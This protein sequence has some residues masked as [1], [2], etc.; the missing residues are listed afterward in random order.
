MAMLDRQTLIDESW[1]LRADTFAHRISG[2]TWQRY[3]WIVLVMRL[4]QRALAHGGARIIINAPPRHGKSQAMSRYLPTWLLNW[5]PG[6]R[7]ILTSYGADF[8]AQ[9]GGVVR[10][11]M[12]N[13][14]VWTKVG[15]EKARRDD[16]RTEEGTGGMLTAGA[17]GPVTGQGGDVILVDDPHKNWEEAMSPT[18]REKTIDWFN[19]TLYTRAEPG[20]SIIVTQTRWHPGDLT[21][22][23]LKYHTDD[24]FHINLPALAEEDDPLGR[25][26][27]EPLCPERYTREDLLRIKAAVGSHIFSGLYQQRPTPLEGGVIKRAWIRHWDVLSEGLE[28]WLTSW[29][30]NFKKTKSGSFVT[31][32]VWAR[33]G[34]DFYLV[35]QYRERADFPTTMKAFCDLAKRYPQVSTHLVESA[36][37]G[38]AI[39]SMLRDK[40]PG[41]V[42]VNVGKD[43]KETRLSAVSSFFESGNVYFPPQRLGVWVD[44]LIEEVVTFPNSAENDQCDSLSQALD[45]YKKAELTIFSM[46]L[47]VGEQT[48]P[49]SFQ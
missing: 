39:I 47:S 20:A 21:G 26:V 45:R 31:G 43:S 16:W 25:A 41:I 15:K 28:E 42:E 11:E 40:I 36:A 34:G 2:G 27:G 5:W 46:D 29:D 8:A 17:R 32:Q 22:Y 3:A 1:R 37:N 48:N 33:C 10:R 35:D 7:I 9:W 49:W 12:S 14:L 30:L 18:I 6:M 19:A 23:L 24:W 44:E 13:D 4:V 38:P